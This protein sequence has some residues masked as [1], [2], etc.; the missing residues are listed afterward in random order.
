MS[1]TSIAKALRTKW[2]SASVPRIVDRVPVVAEA[3]A[4]VAEVEV[5]A[6]AV[7]IMA[8][9]TVAMAEAAAVVVK[10]QA[11]S[12]SRGMKPR[13][14]FF[15]KVKIVTIVP[16]EAYVFFTSEWTRDRF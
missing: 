4:D 13:L 15:S 1:R 3:A 9:V 5:V 7:G 8:V 14:L 12:R 16:S 2:W 6:A 10:H 11:L